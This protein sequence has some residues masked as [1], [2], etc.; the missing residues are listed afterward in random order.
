MIFVICNRSYEQD[1]IMWGNNWKLPCY[2]FRLPQRL[3]LILLLLQLALTSIT[4]LFTFDYNS[5]Y[6]QLQRAL[7]SITLRYLA[8]ENQMVP[9]KSAHFSEIVNNLVK[10]GSKDLVDLIW[11]SARGNVYIVFPVNQTFYSSPT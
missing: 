6:F 7:P 3:Q 10:W 2:V 1:N 5:P 8:L 9:T 4:T 11:Y